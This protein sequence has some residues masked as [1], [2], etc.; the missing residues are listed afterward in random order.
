MEEESSPQ[1]RRDSLKQPKIKAESL[2]AGSLPMRSNN[3][4]TND[5]AMRSDVS[6]NDIR[7]VST[8]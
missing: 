4:S 2:G 3:H 1:L 8:L 6:L 5:S 7:I